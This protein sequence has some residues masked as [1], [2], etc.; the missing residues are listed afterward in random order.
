MTN[1]YTGKSTI[2]EIPVLRKRKAILSEVELDIKPVP[3][4]NVH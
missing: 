2:S 4:S 3:N 1:S